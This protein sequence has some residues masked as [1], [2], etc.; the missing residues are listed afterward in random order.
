MS[1]SLF[2][3]IFGWAQ[4]AF[5]TAGHTLG[6]GA[7][8]PHGLGW[9]SLVGS[10]AT[11]VAVHSASNTGGPSSP[12]DSPTGNFEKGNGSTIYPIKK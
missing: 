10:L 5:T 6:N 11:A 2:A 9:L 4:F 12:N 1:R 7:V 8:L 3:K